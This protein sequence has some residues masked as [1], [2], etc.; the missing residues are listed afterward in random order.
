MKQ[1]VLIF[2]ILIGFIAAGQE[3]IDIHGVDCGIHGSAKYNS[4]SWKL[5][6]YKNR[7]QFPSA[8]DFDTSINL[9]SLSASADPNGFDIDKAV[10]L[11]G[12]V[13][14]VKTGG[15]E[16]C[17]C[18]T[19]D[20]Q[21][22]D[23]HIE[24]VPDE[25]HTDPQYRLIVEVTPRLRLYMADRGE[26]WSTPS[27]K[28]KLIGHH[29]EI[30]GWLFYDAEHETGSFAND[31]DNVIGQK[32]WR[33]SCWEVHPVTHLQLADK[34]YSSFQVSIQQQKSNAPA[35]ATSQKSHAWIIAVLAV[36]VLFILFAFK[37]KK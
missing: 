9:E 21:Y 33:A 1:L 28:Q 17:N 19:N 6:E 2:F 30:S 16:S 20:P 29:V 14:N 27:L 10:I 24:L 37:E 22:R 3:T 34:G 18:K 8:S 11:R 23:T 5:D 15:V 26:D 36:V 32:N 31:P 25:H 7:Y 13:F 4:R 35:S 12:Y